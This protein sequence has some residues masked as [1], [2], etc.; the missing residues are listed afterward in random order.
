MRKLY[1]RR[2]IQ[3]TL[4]VPCCMS[5]VFGFDPTLCDSSGFFVMKFR[6]RSGMEEYFNKMVCIMKRELVKSN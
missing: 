3:H 1:T 5:T 6:N 2:R 4:R